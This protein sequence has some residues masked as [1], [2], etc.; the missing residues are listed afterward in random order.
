[1]SLKTPVPY[2]KSVKPTTCSHLKDSQPR[3][4][5]TTQMKRVRQVSIV[6]RDVAEMERV[7]LRPKKLKPLL[8]GQQE[9]QNANDGTVEPYPIETIIS[10]EVTPIAWFVKTS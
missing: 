9:A 4:K 7:T 8:Y 2:T 3:P 6:L 1:M 5:L 10:R